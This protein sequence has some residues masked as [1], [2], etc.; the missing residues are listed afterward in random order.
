MRSRRRTGR[1]ADFSDEVRQRRRQQQ[2]AFHSID[3]HGDSTP[4]RGTRSSGERTENSSWRE[5]SKTHQGTASSSERRPRRTS[6]HEGSAQRVHQTHET[7]NPAF[8]E[9]E[10]SSVTTSK[11]LPK[12]R[13]RTGELVEQKEGLRLNKFLADAG[14]ASRRGSD[15]LIEAGL[16][17]VNGS[18]VHE[19]GTRVQAS[20]LVTVKGEPVSYLKHLSYLVLNKPKDY[21][22]TTNDEKGRKTVMDLV[23]L[24]QRLYPV[25]RLD[26]N[27]TGTLLITN[28]GELATRLM[29]PSHEIEREYVVGL[30]KRLSPEHAKKIVAGVELEDGT[31]GP[32]EIF[33]NPE[34]KTELRIVLKEGRNREVRR[35]FEH[36][37]YDVK[38]LHRVRYAMISV[39]GL[40]RGEYR[41]LTRDEIRELRRMVG[42][43]D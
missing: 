17:K 33:V 30:D 25:G 38:R 39:A 23:P 35:I 8:S 12:K 15:E 6:S 22:T 7:P 3:T 43:D 2:A 42:L 16:V 37:H 29:H 19:K 40:S 4:A 28:D 21:I 13:T 24:K 41:H 9:R 1:P 14:I 5:R 32:A 27:T 18:V 26:R 20:D 11:V 31:T 10:E 34:D 36:F